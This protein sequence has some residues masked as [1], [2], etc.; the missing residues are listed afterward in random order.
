[1]KRLMQKTHQMITEK[2]SK[3]KPKSQERYDQTAVLLQ[4]SEGDKV[5]VQEKASKLKLPSKRLI[6]FTVVEANTDSRNVTILKRNK[7]VKLH[8][9]LLKKFHE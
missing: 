6:P 4:I 8:K 1:M 9:N 2:P 7:H 5:I 3:S